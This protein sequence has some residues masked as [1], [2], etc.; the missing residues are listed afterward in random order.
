MKAFSAWCRENGRVPLPATAATL[1]E[2]VRHLTVTPGR[3]GT[4]RSPSPIKRAMAAIRTTHE[5]AGHLKP[6]TKAARTILT[7]YRH[8]LAL[9]KDPAAQARK[10]APAVPDALRA[11]LATLDRTTLAGQRDAVLFLLGYATAAR[12]G[13]LVALDIADVAETEEGLD[14]TVYRPKLKKFTEVAVP[15]G[16]VPATCPVRAVRA[17]LAGLA[18]AGRTT[19]PLFVRIDKGG[20]VAR[21]LT[22]KGRPIGDPHGRLTAE[23]VTDVVNGAATAAGLSGKWTGHSLRRGFATAARRAGTHL[24]RIGRHGGWA[25]NSTALLGYVEDADRWTDNPVTGL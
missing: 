8:R 3:R 4:L 13:E 24:E 1:A 19:G 17:Y 11:M 25:D 12:A 15:Y 18:A 22:R 10:A 23:S 9:A 7:G 16:K 5:L 21:P 14:V 2:Y 20:H 6:E